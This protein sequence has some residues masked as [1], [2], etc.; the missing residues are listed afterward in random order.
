M[1]LQRK[2]KKENEK[3]AGAT[4]EARPAKPKKVKREDG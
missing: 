3:A 2:R 4:E 1:K